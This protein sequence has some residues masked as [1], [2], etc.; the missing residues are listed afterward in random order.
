[1]KKFEAGNVE[2]AKTVYNKSLEGDQSLGFDDKKIRKKILSS[3]N[4]KEV[5][6]PIMRDTENTFSSDVEISKVEKKAVEKSDK[7][8]EENDPSTKDLQTSQ[9]NE[10]QDLIIE[11][12]KT[13]NTLI[14]GAGLEKELITPSN[15]E[16]IENTIPGVKESKS[17]F[18]RLT[19]KL[20][21]LISK[22]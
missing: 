10:T 21:D 12:K 6:D 1:M 2:E 11:T 17:I 3:N 4:K 14:Q 8:R 9:I 15:K 19:E 16:F 13:I 7:L 22:S 18:K 5:L 20:T